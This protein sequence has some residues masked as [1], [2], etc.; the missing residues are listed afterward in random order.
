MKKIIIAITAVLGLAA[1]I[2]DDIAP[3]VPVDNENVVL[4]FS[5][6]VPE[7]QTVTKA[8]SDTPNITGLTVFVFD[9]NKML[10]KA[11]NAAIADDATTTDRTEFTVTLPQ[12]PS[13]C[14]VHFVANCPLQTL[15]AAGSETDIMTT[16]T[17]SGTA[18]AYWQCVAVPNLIAANND[19]KKTLV[20]TY[21]TK[22]PL[23]RNFAKITVKL[24]STVSGFELKGYTLINAM[25]SG[26][27]APYNTNAGTFE[28]FN[29]GGTGLGYAVLKANGYDGFVPSG[30]NPETT[31]PTSVTNKASIYTYENKFKDA[32]NATLLVYGAYNGTDGYY[33]VDFVSS[34]NTYNNGNFEILRNL[35]Y[36]VTINSVVGA[37]YP[38]IADALKAVA[39][40]NISAST[41][42]QNLLNISDGTSRLFVDQVVK[43]IVNP[44]AFAIRFRYEPTINGTPDNSGA[45]VTRSKTA[46]AEDAVIADNGISTPVVGTDG[47]ATI[48][49]TPKDLP[50]AAGTVYTEN[51]TIKKGNLSRV[52]T[53]YLHQPYSMTVT[54]TP[55]SATAVKTAVTV[56]TTIPTGLPEEIFPLVFEIEDTNLCLSPNASYASTQGAVPVTTEPSIIPNNTKETFHYKRTLTWAQYSAITAS[57]GNKTFPTYFV[58]NKAVTGIKVYVKGELFGIASN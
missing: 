57:G 18:D 34:S 24:A 30:V 10:L 17:T 35:H 40:N 47:W 23:I 50:T 39:G 38:T 8:F 44:G 31:V 21:F 42:T 19:L 6:V 58:T 33:K 15:P 43:H 9:E 5:V 54:C 29:N 46:A 7:T 12:H 55:T 25:P 20:D 22:I 37:G 2:K 32:D 13:A 41:D 1:C 51:I 49:I 52:V 45:S 3:V 36:K 48:T 28:S 14:T 4:D 53:L 56:N 27:V 26:T 11:V 16:M